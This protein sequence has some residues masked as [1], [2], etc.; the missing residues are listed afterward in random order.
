MQMQ[1]QMRM[2]VAMRT[3]RVAGT[4]PALA[5]PS[6]RYLLLTCTYNIVLCSSGEFS[7]GFCSQ[8]TTLAPQVTAKYTLFAQVVFST[9]SNP[10]RTIWTRRGVGG[11]SGEVPTTTWTLACPTSPCWNARDSRSPQVPRRGFLRLPLVSSIL[12]VII[13]THFPLV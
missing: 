11:N 3:R 1:M 6:P 7:R 9:S 10:S 2:R 12:H 5:S 13:D 8:L 4:W